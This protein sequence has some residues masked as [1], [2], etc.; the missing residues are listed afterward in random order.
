M[1]R[2]RLLLV[3]PALFGLASAQ[4]VSLTGAGATFPYPLYATMFDIYQKETGV[5]VNYQS[6]GSG[7]GQRQL[8]EKTVH[9]GASDAPLSDEQM[10]NYPGKVLHIPTALGAVVATYNLPG[11][12]TPL[13]LTGEV[14]AK[15]FLGQ[16]KTWDDPAIAEINQGVE[17]PALPITVAHRSDGSGTT[18]A[19]VEYLS[20]VSPE[21]EEEVG[22]GTAVEWPTGLGGKGNEGVTGL[23]RQTPGAIGYVELIYAV[24]NDLAYAAIQNQSGEFIIPELASVEAAG[25]IE[26]FPADTRVSL[27]DTPNPEGYPITTLTWIL[28]YEDQE[29]SAKSQAEAKALVDLLWWMTHEGQEQNEKLDYGRLP[30]IAV[31]KSEA[32]IQG[33]KFQGEPLR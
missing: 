2:S 8:L 25:E 26:D 29:I 9:F 24:Q 27:T 13:N 6:I 1:L 5:S 22:V 10:A 17:L 4:Q 33:I 28:V 31:A 11:L 21:W 12:E 30:D 23:V 7:G 3:L 16:V 19:F 18:F 14:L 20:K 15:I 32:L